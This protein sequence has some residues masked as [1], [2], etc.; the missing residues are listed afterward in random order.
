MIKN[1]LV[2]LFAEALEVDASSI[3]PGKALADYSEWNSLAWLTI[4]SLVDER[5]GVRLTG[6]EIRSFVTVKD[7]IDNL[8]AKV[9]G[10]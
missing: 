9:S 5:Y 8:T 7:V 2:E 10:A 1:E 6:P 3:H 4:V